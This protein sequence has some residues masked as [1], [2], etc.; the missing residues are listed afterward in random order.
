MIFRI[1]AIPPSYNRHFKINFNLKQVYLTKEARSFK[2][3]VFLSTPSMNFSDGSIF[4]IQITIVK[5]WL[6]KAKKVK[7]EDIQNM[8]K[9]LIDA[10]SEKL[11]FDDS[12]IYHVSMNKVQSDNESYTEVE[13]NE[14]SH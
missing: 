13:I 3:L 1:Q 5:N 10:I 14:R 2:N 8:D 11:G 6:T 9:L 4:S 7:R 12:R